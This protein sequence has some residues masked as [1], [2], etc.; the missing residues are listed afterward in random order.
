MW[1]LIREIERS[2]P[3]RADPQDLALHADVIMSRPI[4]RGHF[5]IL[6]NEK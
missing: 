2:A 6:A 5:R 4:L 1:R 3:L